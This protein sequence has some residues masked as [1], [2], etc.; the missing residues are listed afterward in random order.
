MTVST[1]ARKITANGNAAATSFSF[2]FKTLANDHIQ[3]VRT[4]ADGFETQLTETVHYSLSLNPDQDA[5]P[6]GTVTYPIGGGPLPVGEKL[7][8]YRVVPLTQDTDLQ[9]Q[10]DF[11]AETHEDVFDRLTM[12]SQELREDVDRS[13][14]VTISS[15]LDPTTYLS[16]V[17]AQAASNADAAAASAASAGA[18]ASSASGSA[19]TASGYVTTLASNYSGYST[20]LSADFISYESTLSGLLADIEAGAVGYTDDGAYDF[21]QVADTISYFNRDFGSIA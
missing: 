2:N 3:V 20:Q 7:T 8:I 18:S 4:G 21:G 13:L 19:T 10:G 9:N 15:G 17:L 16:D 14:K 6:G 12:I 1:T 5:S 11:Y